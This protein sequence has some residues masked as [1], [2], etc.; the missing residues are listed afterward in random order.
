M[1]GDRQQVTRSWK[2]VLNALILYWGR[3]T[4]L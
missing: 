2:P 3:I 4:V 1:V